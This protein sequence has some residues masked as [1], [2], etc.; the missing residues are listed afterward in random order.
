MLR[1][2]PFFNALIINIMIGCAWHFITFIICISVDTSFFDSA[3]KQYRPRKW[4]RGGK[5]Y[6]DILKINKWK[7]LVP[8]HIGK[9]GFSK[10]HIDDVSVEYLDEF[11]METCRSE[12]N[13]TTNCILTVVLFIINDIIMASVLSVIVFICNVPFLL[14]QRYNRFRLERLRGSVIRKQEREKRKAELSAER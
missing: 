12:W 4:E 5:F 14:I 10:E 2:E 7:D 1:N 13:H 6:S 9:D 11:I 3:K 8:Q